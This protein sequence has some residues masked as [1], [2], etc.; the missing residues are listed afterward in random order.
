MKHDTDCAVFF[1][2][3]GLR[4]SGV[5]CQTGAEPTH[6]E[7]QKEAVSVTK[8]P[9]PENE[10]KPGSKPPV[11]NLPIRHR[12]ASPAGALLSAREPATFDDA[13]THNT[14]GDEA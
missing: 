6:P 14:S 8:K 9:L 2:Y 7:G 10:A 1:I 3:H 12:V 5:A 4:A 11:R 13:A